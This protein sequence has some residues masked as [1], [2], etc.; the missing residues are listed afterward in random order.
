MS[1]EALVK[2]R[3]LK[4][5]FPVRK[6]FLARILYG[7]QEY[8]RAVDGI[9]FDIGEGEISCLT[10]ESGCGKTTTAR[11]ILRL[12]PPTAGAVYYR[13]RDLLSLSKREMRK[14]RHEIQMIFQDPY[15]SLNPRD[16]VFDLVNDPLEINRKDLSYKEKRELVSKALEDVRLAPEEYMDRYPHELSGGER[17]RVAISRALVL[18]PLFI[19]ADEPVSMLDASVRIGI[20]N[21]LLDL[22]DEYKLTFLYITHDLAQARYVGDQI[23]VM[24]LGKIV[25]RGAAKDI[26]EEPTHPY[27][28][29]LIS[30]VPIPDPTMKSKKII[31]KGEVPDPINLPPGCRFY[32]RCPYAKGI[33]RENEPDLTKVKENHYVSCHLYREQG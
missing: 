21:L 17:Q 8:L 29:A 23:G 18:N 30:N 32:P 2:V 16:R 25:E 3:N 6:G 1:K 14:M 12:I 31:V 11:L 13:E 33:C 19:V 28:Q 15:K 20:L 5:Y 4:K 24:Y 9:S 10:G 22:R 27:T 26:I 7:E